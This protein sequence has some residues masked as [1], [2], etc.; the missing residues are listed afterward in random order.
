MPA[1]DEKLD[2]LSS[3]PLFRDCSSRE[4]R[5]IAGLAEVITVPAGSVLV[6]EGRQG[7]EFFVISS[8]DARVV[9]DGR[10][11]A[12]LRPGDHFGELALLACT[13]RDA[14]VV[15]ETAME[16]V[17]IEVRS[18]RG[19][20]AASPSFARGMLEALALRLQASDAALSYSPQPS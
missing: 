20:L 15:S 5:R 4:L 12:T 14:T 18:F 7:F 3:L 10:T 17:V 13:A 8:G 1:T 19:L 6:R 2:L 11:V 9:I 16:L